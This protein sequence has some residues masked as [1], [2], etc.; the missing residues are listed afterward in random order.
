M[1]MLHIL[2]NPFYSFLFLLLLVSLS[3]SPANPL[4]FKFP[5]LVN[6]VL[7]LALLVLLLVL[8]PI[9]LLLLPLLLVLAILL[10]L[11]VWAL[12]G[13]PMVLIMPLITCSSPT[14]VLATWK[15]TSLPLLLMEVILH[16][17]IALVCSFL[18][19]FCFF[20][21]RDYPNMEPREHSWRLCRQGLRWGLA[22]R[23]VILFIYY[24]LLSSIILFLSSNN[25]IAGDTYGGA[26]FNVRLGGP[27]QITPYGSNCAC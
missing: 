21:R 8:L 3:I 17:C 5:F 19:T 16:Y 6:H 9:L 7:L 10:L 22:C 24:F 12:L 1:F 20:C 13:P 25:I 18:L 23:Y 11:L 27:I 15:I 4:A 14:M 26:G 2:F